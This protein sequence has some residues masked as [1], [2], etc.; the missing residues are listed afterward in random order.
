MDN[1]RY[2]PDDRRNAIRSRLLV[3]GSL[4]VEELAK[5]LDVSVATVR[6]DLVI[7]EEEGFVH[8]T[9]GGAMVDTPRGADQAFSLRENTDQAAKRAIARAAAG[10]INAERTFFLNDGSTVLAL[11]RELVTLD[12]QMTVATCGINI[13][14]T[15]S[16]NPK[17]QTFLAGGVV[18][19]RTMGTTGGFVD[20]M[21]SVLHVDI[22]FIA[23]ES[24]NVKDGMTY[25]YEEDARIARK[26]S[27]R[28]E[29]TVALAT[30]RKLMA[31]DCFT[32]FGP[33]RIDLLITDC[34]KPS[35]VKPFEQAGIKV[36]VAQVDAGGD[37]P[38]S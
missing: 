37:F 5:E 36:L 29:K 3:S 23:A 38:I 13:A 33:E 32:G 26:M 27:E 14:T 12:T 7:L 34:S 18:R 1:S 35:I 4:R 21:L 24:V 22:A 25:S 10:L 20:Q 8:R 19:H 16:E 28:A 17:I 2:M 15:L 6:R 31:H 30:T 9:H 11:A